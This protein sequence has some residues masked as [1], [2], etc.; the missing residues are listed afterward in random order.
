M[1]PSG[2]SFSSSQIMSVGSYDG[3]I[4]LISMK[5]WQVR[6]SVSQPVSQLVTQEIFRFVV[7]IADEA[8]KLIIIHSGLIVRIIVPQRV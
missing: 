3:K 4:R 7:F 8:M 2:D 5:S 6:Q 1:S